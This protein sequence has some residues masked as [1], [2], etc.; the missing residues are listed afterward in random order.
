MWRNL[1]KGMLARKKAVVKA[2]NHHSHRYASATPGV[3]TP[4]VMAPARMRRRE[5][6]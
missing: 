1:V 2:W 3:T 4:G 6:A 5:R